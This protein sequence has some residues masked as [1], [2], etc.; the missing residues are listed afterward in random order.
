MKDEGSFDCN[1][2][3]QSDKEISSKSQK[4]VV[5][6]MKNV[7]EMTTALLSKDKQFW[8][9]FAFLVSLFAFLGWCGFSILSFYAVEVFTK[10]SSP[11]H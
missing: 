7:T 11:H 2:C 6:M 8:A 9:T 3:Q 10:V 5:L 4:P 1:L